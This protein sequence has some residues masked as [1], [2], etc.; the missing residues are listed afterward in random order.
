LF[1]LLAVIP[2]FSQESPAGNTAEGAEPSA[3]SSEDIVED[4]AQPFSPDDSTLYVIVDYKFTVKGIS[5]PFALL[6]KL[7]EKGEF[8]QGETI[9]GKTNLEKYISN[10]T[11]IYINQRVLKD[12]A[13]VTYSTGD[14]NE[15]GT[16]PVTIMIKVEDAWNIIALPRPYY[17]NNVVDITIK[18]RDY[19][20]LGT[21]NPLR[22]DIGYKYDGGE[23]QPHSFLLGVY[24]DTHFKFLGYYWN[25]IFDNTVQYRVKAPV[26]YENLTGLSMDLPFRSTTFTFGINERLYLNQENSDWAKE[27]GYGTYQDGLYM[28]SNPYV[29]WSIPTG[30]TVSRFGDLTYSL[31]TSATFNHEL[32]PWHLADDRKGP[33]MNFG[34][35]LGFGN[36]DWHGNYREGLSFSVGNSYQY[37]FHREIY[38]ISF[39]FTGIGHHIVKKYFAVSA[40]LMYRYWYS[41]DVTSE[42]S[43]I[44]YNLRGIADTSITAFQMLSLNLD[45]PFRLFAFTPSKWFKN[46]KLSF[47]DLEVHASPV[48]DLALYRQKFYDFVGEKTMYRPAEYAATA[49][50]EL[51]IFSSFIRSL[52]VRVGF[53]INAKQFLKDLI[54]EKSFRIPG[55]DNREIYF[56]MGHFY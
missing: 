56:I 27:N 38:N 1:F 16:Y 55:G 34:H 6:Y 14:R 12:N 45:L 40:R 53:A 51:V 49:G 8:R 48:I 47:F 32:P 3:S 13:E 35:S 23:E 31:S 19:N 33:F 10:I 41:S 20:F 43:Y 17:K 29:S 52:Y 26:Y 22:I 7:V 36:I 50:L 54:K 44:S 37:D 46:N 28:T 21:M 42:G 39:D 11:Q 15:D 25:F 4:T 30:L 18:A 2:L 24:F 9:T 5:R